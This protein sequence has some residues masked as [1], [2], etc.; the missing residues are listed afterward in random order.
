[1]KAICI[2][3]FNHYETRMQG[4]IEYL[5]K[6][7]YEVKYL[8]SDFNHFSKTKYT[9]DYKG[10]K[11][12]HVMPYKKNISLQRLLSHYCFSKEVMKE[13][14][15]ERPDMIYCVIPPNSLVKS[16][17]LFKR[18]NS[19]VKLVFDVYDRW[20]ESFPYKKPNLIIREAFNYW[21]NLRDKYIDFADLLIS[22][23][24]DG[25]EDLEKKYNREA[26]VLMPVIVT[27]DIPDYT[28]EVNEKI[29]FCYLGNINYI[30]DIELGTH[31]LSGVAKYKKVDLHII[32]EG[33]NKDHWTDL[34]KQAGV[35]VI[36][37]GVLFE[38]QEKNK[39]FEVCDLGLNIPR[40]E[41]ESTMSLKSVE[42]MK[43]AL[44]FINSGL[45]D[46]EEIVREF[47]I[48][49]NV[50]DY[51]VVKKIVSLTH[52]DI[53]RMHN[54]SKKCYQEKFV[55]QDYDSILSKVMQ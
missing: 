6:K 3:C 4:L 14:R 34:L 46:N 38:P 32:G 37:H 53:F 48:G 11:Q 15:R 25:K 18:N 44:P 22:V 51:D 40:P 5:E 19:K 16:L 24:R 39:V 23:S 43:A 45:G 8:I 55:C 54:N 1:M 50:K 41:I 47:D 12:I 49:I 21:T 2:S 30:T 36:C 26:E 31:I 52:D 27:G 28:F 42:Y 29:S 7:G 35:N 20:P 17:G 9:V 33:Q 10:A 13:I